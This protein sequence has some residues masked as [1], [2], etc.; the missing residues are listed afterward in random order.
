ME[1][2]LHKMHPINALEAKSARPSSH[3][4]NVFLSFSWKGCKGAVG[5]AFVLDFIPTTHTCYG[6]L[7]YY[8]SYAAAAAVFISF[9]LASP[10]EEISYLCGSQNH[11]NSY[12]PFCRCTYIAGIITK[13]MWGRHVDGKTHSNPL[14]DT[15]YPLLLAVTYSHYG[16]S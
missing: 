5:A 12:L 6:S 9:G 8:G 3:A 14:Q 13:S 10:S 2:A 11:W 1:I 15:L 4:F 16:Y 7:S